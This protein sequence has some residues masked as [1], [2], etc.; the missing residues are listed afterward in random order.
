LYEIDKLEQTPT[1]KPAYWQT[2][3]G[4]FATSSLKNL[5]APAARPHTHPD[6]GQPWSA[7]RV[8]DERSQVPDL[9]W[10]PARPDHPGRAPCS[11][12][13]RWSRPHHSVARGHRPTLQ[14]NRPHW[15]TP[16]E[17]RRGR[18]PGRRRPVLPAETT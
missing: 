14:A 18:R 8:R 3:H 10:S 4:R 16:P 15:W 17:R 2:A 6:S 13:E 9:S 11:L 7:A 12:P 5:N 1:L